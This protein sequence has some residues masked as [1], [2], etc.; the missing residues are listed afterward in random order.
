MEGG[1]DLETNKEA[2]L[3]FSVFD[4]VNGELAKDMEQYLGETAHFV[5]ISQDLKDFV[6]AHPV[7]LD[8]VKNEN[9][10]NSAA[11]RQAASRL[12][13]NPPNSMISIHAAFPKEGTYKIFAEFKRNGNVIVVPFVVEVKKGK[14]EKLM[15]NVKIPDGAFK[16]VVN[17]DGFAP[18]EISL[19]K[20]KFKKI[21]FL[22]VDEGVCDRGIT[23]TELQTLKK[24]PIGEV[25]LLDIPKNKTGELHFTCNNGKFN[26]T[27]T[28]Q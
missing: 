10:Q 3:N 8:N 26:G 25:V 27:V 28:L 7:S 16:I 2:M 19:S 4:A 18:N 23:F 6:H 14:S 13:N 22:R 24:L 11:N 5:I 1:N 17:R 21:A 15:E 20:D 9:L 12:A